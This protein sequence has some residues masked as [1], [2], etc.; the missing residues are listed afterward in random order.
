MK[1]L[2]SLVLA[3]IGPG[4]ASFA[5]W[6]FC[7]QSSCAA[8]T[9][10]EYYIYPDGEVWQCCAQLDNLDGLCTSATPNGVWIGL[11]WV[12]VGGP[13]SSK[14]YMSQFGTDASFVWTCGGIALATPLGVTDPNDTPA[15]P[16]RGHSDDPCDHSI[17]PIGMPTWHVSEPY[18]SLWLT[19]EPLGYQPSLGPRVSFSLGFAQQEASVGYDT[20]TFNLGKKWSFSWLSYV[21]LDAYTNPV[22]HLGSGG[23]HTF[24]NGVDYLTD[25][26]LK[27]DTT[28]GYTLTYPDGRS[29]VYALIVTN[30]T[31]GF[32]KA[33]LTQRLNPAAQG[34]K[35]YYASYAPSAPV[36]RLLS[37]VDGDGLT[38]SISY[39]TNT[40]YSTNLI[41][42]VTDPFG[43]TA[44]MVYDNGGHLTNLTDVAGISGSFIYDNNEWVTNLTTPYGQT[45][46]K[47]TDVTDQSGNTVIPNG[48]AIEITEPDAAKQLYLF[49]NSA[50]GIPTS[51]ATNQ[52]PNLS[53]FTGTL[54]N[55]AMQLNNSF[56]WNKLQYAGLSSGFLSSGNVSQLTTNDFLRGRM[57][58]WLRLGSNAVSE[59]LSMERAASPDG[60]TEGQKT[61]YDYAGKT[62]PSYPGTQVMPLFTAR[63]LPD[64]T[65]RF[66]RTDRNSF[67]LVTASIDTYSASGGVGQRTNIL[68]YATNNIDLLTV[69]NAIGVQTANNAY[70]NYHEVLTNYNA[71]GEMTV[72]NYNG[73]LQLASVALPTGL[74]T[75]NT[76]FTSGS[77]SNHLNQTI[78][79]AVVG[80]STNYYRTNSYT[81]TNDLVWT[82]TDP[83]G[84]L[85]SNTWDN[86]QRIV[87]VD[88]PDG[89]AVVNAYANLDLV[90]TTDRLGYTTSSGYNTIRQ[91][92]AVTNAN[93][94][95]SR[96]G[97]C[98]CGSLQAVTN[99]FGTSVQSVTT[100]SWDLQGNLVQSV[101]PDGY[102]LTYNYN[103]LA[104]LTN[105]TDGT[106]STTNSF[107]NQGLQF[108]SSN[109]FGQ[110]SATIFDALDRATN[111]VDANGV[112]ISSTFDN[113]NR[114][115]SRAYPDSG[116]EHFAYTP[117]VA[118]LT[119]YTNQLGTNVV[120][121]TYDPLGR[122]TAEV[123]PGISTNSFAYDGAN[124]LLTLTDGKS[125]VTTWHYDQ[126]GR[127]T[128]K[129]DAATNVIFHIRLRSRQPAHQ[130]D[131]RGQ[132]GYHV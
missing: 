23:S 76:Y 67:G 55:T 95:V 8:I 11:Q 103:A 74:I 13:S 120:N 92:V 113:L 48:R 116:V 131:Q 41:R 94:V 122:K 112:T 132:G 97:Y 105:T 75:T 30:S 125:Q 19:D 123:Y 12:V 110:V 89:T 44:T 31:G 100:Y 47:I 32:L 90:Q 68:T 83:L 43:R 101:G 9:V 16:G 71:L 62:N 59:T 58:H 70:N 56:H 106:T 18:I 42:Q 124:N 26:G 34:T 93:G 73:N 108:A 61:W 5:D 115:L 127:T 54:D 64:G 69:T 7:N 79:Y 66:T 118:A 25:F 77:S 52:V 14:F 91:L 130:P 37:V 87:R 86:L 96:Y 119:G 46:F 129:V 117:N 88:Y 102:A 81:W 121:Y 21:T 4:S 84:L 38:N 10:G 72:F 114:I 99:A 20:N 63:V 111:T 107:N 33:F 45:K 28:N 17:M 36:I 3:T 128:N 53:P 22:V 85:T 50:P 80:G 29:D 57:Y 109:A 104:Q 98:S 49:T 60:T 24:T 126:F 40:A 65:T 15:L 82:H 39:S 2:L 78:D 1:K 35:L 27:G 51:Y 6:T